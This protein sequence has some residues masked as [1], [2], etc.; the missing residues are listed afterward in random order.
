MT[1]S[2]NDPTPDQGDNRR[3]RATV[4]QLRGEVRDLESDVRDLHEQLAR[5]Y[6][7]LEQG[8]ATSGLNLQDLELPPPLPGPPVFERV[9][10]KVFRTAAGAVRGVLN[11]VRPTHVPIH[12]LRFEI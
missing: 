4:E 5:I 11:A 6:D 12:S 8:S 3:L 7:R 10:R 1:V 2:G 9:A